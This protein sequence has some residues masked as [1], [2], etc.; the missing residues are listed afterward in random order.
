[1]LDVIKRKVN[2]LR[3]VLIA[4]LALQSATIAGLGFIAYEAD[5]RATGALVVAEHS[6]QAIRSDVA[7]AK[8]ASETARDYGRLTAALGPRCGAALPR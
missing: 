1:M 5:A 8:S 3:A 6:L 2:D 7:E 4:V